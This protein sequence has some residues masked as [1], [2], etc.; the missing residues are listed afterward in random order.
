MP[1]KTHVRPQQLWYQIFRSCSRLPGCKCLSIGICA[2]LP[3]CS[4]SKERVEPPSQHSR[5]SQPAAATVDHGSMHSPAAS[6]CQVYTLILVWMVTSLVCSRQQAAVDQGRGPARPVWHGAASFPVFLAPSLHSHRPPT[7]TTDPWRPV[8]AA[9]VVP[10]TAWMPFPANKDV[11]PPAGITPRAIPAHPGMKDA[12]RLDIVAPLKGKGVWVA[13]NATVIGNVKIGD[14][15]SI[16]Y[17][18]VL[19]GERLGSGSG[20]RWRV[21]GGL[22]RPQ[23]CWPTI[24]TTTAYLHMSCEPGVAPCGCTPPHTPC[25]QQQ[26][27]DLP[28]SLL[29]PPPPPPLTPPPLPR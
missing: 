4:N 29:V 16:W 8:P 9:A 13:Q 17:G 1:Q 6:P 15:S 23:Q 27:T 24:H 25:P 12:P 28:A 26:G 20:S 19:R 5:D 14:N 22:W 21:E 10:N 11:T 7:T 2:P 18:A 3:A